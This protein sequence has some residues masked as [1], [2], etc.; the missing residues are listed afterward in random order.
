MKPSE[1]EQNPP[2]SQLRAEAEGRLANG[3]TTENID[4][5]VQKLLQELQV[6]Q[7]ELEI[8]NENLRQAQIALEESRDR[9]VDFFEFA[10]VA[11]LTLTDQGLVADINLT[12]AEL[13]GVARG[14]L[15]QQRFSHFVIADD[16]DRWHAYFLSVLK[17]DHKLDCELAL[18]RRDGVR[19]HARLDSLRLVKDGHPSV[20]R[21]VL[22]DV[23]ERKQAADALRAEEEFFRMIA[24]NV[25]DF[26]AV[27][28]LEG[29]RLY[30]S[31]S[32][33]RFFGDIKA[34]KGTDSFA[35]IHPDD[36]E[37]VE[38][39]FME[40]VRTG[41]SY[42]L[43]FRFLLPNGSIRYMES[44]GALIRNSHGL[45]LRVLVVS[46]DITER[47]EDEKEIHN[48][49]FYDTLTQVPNRRLLSDRLVQA[50]AVSKRSGRYG[51]L[52]FLDLDNFKS[53]NDMHGHNL[54]DLLL[55]EVA[56]RI[57][58]CVREMDTVARFGGDEFVVVL[59]E[60]DQ[61][62]AQSLAQSRVAAEKIRAI[63][64][65]PYL[66]QLEKD[67]SPPVMIEHHCT[68]SIG[69]VLFINHEASSEDILKWAD[70]AMYQAKEAG[71]DVI[72]Y[73][74]SSA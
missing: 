12:G 46:R 6:H 15:L 25:E 21:M 13:L 47:I 59:S 41:T 62:K 44:C 68:A 35:E 16:K 27:L 55:R 64:A 22:T 70:L 31:P 57:T 1:E 58:S 73:Y 34:M 28:D 2:D 51:G 18:Q 61:D 50:L 45:P 5:S 30:N 11:H 37:R 17:Q 20:V 69:V 19:L 48:L 29:R 40:T 9:F 4:P 56:R 53:L 42:R 14:K 8:Q 24:E 26:I 36:R 72:R 33:A 67:G 23:T 74:D 63:L 49:A 32:Y 43:N 39:T 52:I 54:G 65:E 71:R 38:Y 60:L 3:P 7:I 66:L 10:P